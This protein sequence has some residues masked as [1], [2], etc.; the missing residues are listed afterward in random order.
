MQALRDYVR[1][2]S[3]PDRRDY[4]KRC[5][6][7]RQYLSQLCGEHS[8]PSAYMAITLARE[9][10]WAFHPSAIYP[11]LD[12]PCAKCINSQ[13]ENSPLESLEPVA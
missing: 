13:K 8:K 2:L 1:C 5:G 6:T 4:A 12:I 7:S 3:I 11:A 10:K 9:S